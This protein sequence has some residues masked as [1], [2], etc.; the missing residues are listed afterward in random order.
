M[1]KPHQLSQDT[2]KKIEALLNEDLSSRKIADLLEISKSTVNNYRPQ[3]N[4]KKKQGPKIAILDVETAA[5]VG[6]FFGRFNINISQGNVLKEGS[7]MLV[8]V[9]L[10]WFSAFTDKDFSAVLSW[11]IVA[12]S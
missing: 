11:R 2:I 12:V 9:L 8:F 6:M 4:L 3:L 5:T 7:W 10:P 1:S